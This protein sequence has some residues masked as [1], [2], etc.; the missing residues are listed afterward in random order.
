EMEALRE[1][2]GVSK[3]VED[4]GFALWPSC[5]DFP[6]GH[7]SQYYFHMSTLNCQFLGTPLA[8]LIVLDEVCP[9]I[10][11]DSRVALIPL[12]TPRLTQITKQSRELAD[13]AGNIMYWLW[14]TCEKSSHEGHKANPTKLEPCPD[15]SGS[16]YGFDFRRLTDVVAALVEVDEASN[17][18]TLPS[19]HFPR[20]DNIVKGSSWPRYTSITDLKQEEDGQFDVIGHVIACEDLDMYDKNGKSGKKKPLTLVDHEGSELQCTLWSKICVQNAYNATKLFLFD[21]T[22]PT[23]D[24]E[25]QDVKEYS[26][27]LLEK[28]WKN[29]KIRQHVYSQPPKTLPR[30]LF[31]V[32]QKKVIR[33]KDI[34]D[35]EADIPK[36][37]ASGKDVQCCSCHQNNVSTS[38]TGSRRNRYH[39]VNSLAR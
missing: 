21:A 39:V 4:H 26:S 9:T 24:E 13:K 36:K 34:I 27:R 22:Q 31:L 35:L 19:F 15:F 16:F 14:V 18:R 29:K 6:A 11:N 3:F 33:E 12:V 25:F 2:K 1:A 10:P 5:E 8:G 17:Y 30:K 7:L 28:M 20:Q 23:V 38:S 32:I 37:S